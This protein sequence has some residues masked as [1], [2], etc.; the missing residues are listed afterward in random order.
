MK[1]VVII[2]GG[3]SFTSRREYLAFLRSMNITRA[4]LKPR[5]G[6]KANLQSDLG[7]GWQVVQPAMPNKGNARYGE[8]KV[9]FEK[10]R[11][12]I[13]SG[14]LFIGHSLGGIFLAKYFSENQWPKKIGAIIL[15]AAPHNRTKGIGD[16]RL[17]KPLTKLA[18]QAPLVFLFQSA[19]DP[20]VSFSE[21]TAYHRA[22]PNAKV[23]TLSRRGHFTQGHFPELVRLLKTIR[24]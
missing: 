5:L 2:H 13:T 3:D 8:W 24:P 16:F 17:V 15:V 20:L 7:R 23:H 6:W 12:F 21:M 18:K 4:S 22:L 11:P 14:T 1:Q 9:W 19:S 10:Y